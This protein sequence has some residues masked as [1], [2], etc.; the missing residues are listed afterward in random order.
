MDR[1]GDSRMDGLIKGVGQW[2][3]FGDGVA[4]FSI[5]QNLLYMLF[6]LYGIMNKKKYD[7]R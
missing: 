7:R 2:G 3:I 4:I 6:Y 5:F 1:Y